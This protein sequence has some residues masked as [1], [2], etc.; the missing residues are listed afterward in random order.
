MREIITTVP[1]GA[2]KALHEKMSFVNDFFVSRRKKSLGEQIVRGDFGYDIAGIVSH[3]ERFDDIFVATKVLDG[4][5]E[6]VQ[7]GEHK[8]SERFTASFVKRV[9]DE[10]QEPV[11]FEFDKNKLYFDIAIN[12]ESQDKV[13]KVIHFIKLIQGYTFKNPEISAV[14]TLRNSS[15]KHISIS[16][17]KNQQGTVDFSTGSG[18][19]ADSVTILANKVEA[20]HELTGYLR[21]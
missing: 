3:I 16:A 4:F 17:T 15:Y 9:K 8:V 14:V 6:S 19:N 21:A 18:F 12:P 2:V 10:L 11:N 20:W 5:V 7:N 1:T 13:H